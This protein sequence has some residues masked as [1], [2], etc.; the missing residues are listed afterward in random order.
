MPPCCL[1]PAIVAANCLKYFGAVSEMPDTEPP[2]PPAGK[3][4]VL[5][6]RAARLP[7]ACFSAMNLSRR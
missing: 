1:A 5:Q 4:P 3:A 6:S 7:V 2:C